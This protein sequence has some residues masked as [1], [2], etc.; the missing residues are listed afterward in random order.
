VLETSLADTVCPRLAVKNQLSH[1]SKANN[2]T[3]TTTIS[4]QSPRATASETQTSA[5]SESLVWRWRWRRRP[6]AHYLENHLRH[7]Q[8]SRASRVERKNANLSVKVR[9]RP[10]SMAGARIQAATSSLHTL[11][12]TLKA[13]DV[14][15]RHQLQK[16]DKIAWRKHVALLNA[17]PSGATALY[18]AIVHSIDALQMH[19]KPQH[20]SHQLRVVLTD[21]DDTC[22]TQHTLDSVIQ[23][24]HSLLNRQLPSHAA[25]RRRRRCQVGAA[26]CARQA[27]SALYRRSRRNRRCHPRRLWHRVQEDH[28]APAK[29]HCSHDNDNDNDD[30]RCSRSGCPPTSHAAVFVAF[31]S[32]S[33]ELRRTIETKIGWSHLRCSLAAALDRSALSFSS[34]LAKSAFTSTS[35]ASS[36]PRRTVRMWIVAS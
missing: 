11:V 36:A 1:W 10:C 15:A 32:F 9:C 34:A 3:H 20:D 5:R 17:A 19:A 26:L 14:L 21:G 25:R 23:R 29:A 6:L 16:F 4:T 24:V 13:R 33:A 7:S 27:Q 12:Q 28:G 18:D 35:R 8:H 31:K 22:S 2:T 30:K